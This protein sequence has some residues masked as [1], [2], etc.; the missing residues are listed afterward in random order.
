MAAGHERRAAVPRGG[1]HETC[2]GTDPTAGRVGSV[3]SNKS[4]WSEEDLLRELATV[5]GEAAKLDQELRAT[6]TAD[7]VEV[8]RPGAS[9]RVPV[10]CER[11]LAGQH[12][13]GVSFSFMAGDG[14]P[15]LEE[16]RT[17]AGDVADYC[18]VGSDPTRIPLVFFRSWEGG[19]ATRGT[20]LEVAEDFRLFWNL[21]EDRA[22]GTFVHDD[23]AGQQEDVVR[24]TA[25]GVSIRG[26][27][28]RRYLAARQFALVSQGLV[29]VK[30]VPAPWQKRS[31]ILVTPDMCVEVWGGDRVVRYQAI[32]VLAPPPQEQCGVWPFEAPKQF[33]NFIID[34][35]EV[36]RP[37][38]HT[39]D[40]DYARGPF[41]Q[42]VFFRRTVLDRY[43]ADPDRYGVKDGLVHGPSFT[44]PVDNDHDDI[45]V[46]YLGDLGRLPYT[47]QQHWRAHNV[48]PS[49]TISKTAH[50]RDILGQFAD[51]EH[52]DH[53]FKVSYVELVE[54]WEK[55][56]DWP[57]YLPPAAGDEHVV[58]GLHVPTNTSMDAFEA[59]IVPLAKCTVDFLNEAKLIE[60]LDETPQGGINRL[61]ASLVANHLPGDLPRI[62]R[63]VQGARSNTGAHRKSRSFDMAKLLDGAHDPAIRFAGILRE[64]VDAFDGLRREL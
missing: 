34:A 59:E 42:P 38:E 21:Y 47:E 51:A 5:H 12:V 52:V 25:D 16:A 53:R 4:T 26:S 29:D 45:V 40:V 54:T 58:A 57:L 2:V 48:T 37:A 24:I 15:H 36:G 31:E 35:D 7:W 61:E 20:V 50:Q 56:F 43:F 14:L 33:C 32:H 17:D 10:L 62:L 46:A 49:G 22:T 6:G 64:I 63:I 27:F 41:L 30:G 23:D 28:L 8:A 19:P 55:R 13:G 60:A 18:E 39:A 3:S 9:F 11:D 1:R 44:L